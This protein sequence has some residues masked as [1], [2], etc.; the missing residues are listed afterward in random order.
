LAG[1]VIRV[2]G[3]GKEFREATGARRVAA[4]A[5]VDLTVERGELV[6]IVGPSGCGKSTLLNLIAGLDRPSSG[7]IALDGRRVTGP[8][9]IGYVFQS[10]ALLP[11][12]T[13]QRNA[14]FALEIAG[15]P[16]ER[17]RQLAAG[18]LEKLGLQGFGDHFPHQLS[19]GMRKRLQLATILVAEPSVLLMD[20][21]FAAL[22]AQTRTVIEDD[23]LRL[24]AETGKTVVFV[25][26]D[27]TEA[28]AMST[29]V[30]IMTARPGRVKSEYPIT[31]PSGTSTMERRLHRDFQGLCSR[32]WDDLRAEVGTALGSNRT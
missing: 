16:P 20:E 25:T 1:T 24:W 10:D 15:V 9:K 12:R 22:D 17:R 2:Q 7:E 4:L 14:E 23:F 3:I 27:L 6:S 13:A 11:W 5:G 29:R 32:I 30:V 8:R 26:H 19:G 31:L 18:W 28:V 21:P